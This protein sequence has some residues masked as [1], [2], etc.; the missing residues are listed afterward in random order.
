MNLL[1]RENLQVLWVFGALE[2]L[3]TL[4]YLNDVPIYVGEAGIDAYIYADDS[5]HILFEDQSDVGRI[6]K[7]IANDKQIIEQPISESE[8]ESIVRLLLEYKN[9]RENLVKEGLERKLKA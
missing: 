7:L 2:R 4:G 5:R 1:I 3:A 8:S 9:N 6:F